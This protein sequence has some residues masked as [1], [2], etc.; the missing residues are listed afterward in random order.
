M[1][2]QIGESLAFYGKIF[3]EFT[4]SNSGPFFTENDYPDLT[5]QKWLVTGATG[6]IGFDVA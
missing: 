6:G 4:F 3:N 2:G 5:G 1:L